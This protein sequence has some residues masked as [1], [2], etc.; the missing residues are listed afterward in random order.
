MN[1]IRWLLIAFLLFGH[2][3]PAAAMA[4][5]DTPASN[6][7][8]VDLAT[9]VAAERNLVGDLLG[10]SHL[11]VTWSSDNLLDIARADEL[12]LIEIMAANPGVDPWLPGKN[13]EVLLPSAHLLPD[14]P[15]KGIVVNLAELRLYFFRGDTDPVVSFPVGV[16][17]DGF[18]TPLGRT[19]VVRKKAAP[20]WYP[21]KNTRA[22][23]PDLPAAVPPGPDNP[24]GEYAIYLGWPTYLIHGTNKPD[25]VGR[26][27]S[28][29]CIRLYPEN[30]AW[31]FEHV[32]TGI[33]VTVVDQ[34][35]KIGWSRGELFLEVHP[36]RE[37]IDQIE[38]TGFAKPDFIADPMDRILNAAGD[39]IARIDWETVERV[40]AERRGYPVRIT[41]PRQVSGPTEAAP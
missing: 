26:R 6:A 40:L 31:L 7:F 29:G 22:D 35:V 3:S 16:G 8:D 28:R 2:A 39:D 24:L 36:T 14:A 11:H 34:P 25:G 5:D 10:E 32:K 13:V 33:P 38:A 9:A 30:I 37:Q 4:E 21:T 19:K 15:R 20:A 12:G 1:T 18:T 27:V 17:R 23:N 41:L